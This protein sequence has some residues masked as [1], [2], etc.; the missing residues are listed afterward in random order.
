MQSYLDKNK[1]YIRQTLNI[2]QSECM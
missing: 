2:K 1:T